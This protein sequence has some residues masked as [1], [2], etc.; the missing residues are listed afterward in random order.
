MALTACLW[1]ISCTSPATPTAEPLTGPTTQWPTATPSVV[2]ATRTPSDVTAPEVQLATVSSVVQP[3]DGLKVVASASDEGTVARMALEVDGRVV[4]EANEG[5][6][7][8]NVDTRALAAGEHVLVVQAW[9][10]AGNVGRAEAVFALVVPTI[11]VQP[12]TTATLQPEP[13]LAL[14]AT[15]TPR[16]T[17]EP[18]VAASV[19][20]P[21]EVYWDE[22]SI[23]TYGYQQALYTDSS[24]GH[25]YP[26]LHWDQVTGAT[27]QTYRTLVLRNAYVQLTL[28][29]DLG[30]R[31]YQCRFLPTGQDLLYNN[32]VIKPTH[33]GPTDQGWWLAVGGIEFCL[34]VDEHGYLT[35]EPWQAEVVR[36]DDGSVTVE[37]SITERSRNL[38]ARVEL[39][40]QP[41][42]A[43]FRLRMVLENP[44]ASAK[45][46]QY[47]VNAMLSPGGHGVQSSLRFYYPTTSVTVHSRGDGALPDAGNAMSWPVADG[48]DLSLYANWRNWLGFFAPDLEAAYT[49]VYD[50]VAS[51]G[52]VRTFASDVAQG[53]K[54]F[55]FGQ[56]FD[57]AVYTDDGTQYVEMWGGLT[58][59][60]WD[61]ATLEANGRVAWDEYWY[62][63]A[64]VDDLSVATAQAALSV[65]R[66]QDALDVTVASPGEHDWTLCVFQGENALECRPCSVQPGV[67]F[68]VRLE[69]VGGNSSQTLVVRITDAAGNE[70]LSY[71]V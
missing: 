67:P 41:Q 16:P 33:W 8:Y 30:G 4:H 9:D 37:L 42:E 31:I 58:P 7:R 1:L 15:P 32:T 35:A 22:V 45:T 18:T 6:L 25:P 23:A 39:T 54:L 71:P 36:Q 59:T 56:G 53:N 5:S 57:P 14:S 49:A 64:G 34:P 26:L 51:V 46:F 27:P 20:A 62:V 55:G 68:H 2:A 28:L 50:P 19:P 61:Y 3:T 24:T 65:T 63:L 52:M 44:E 48:R 29:P 12:V 69:N 13:S 11:T 21:V 47:W 60:F 10:Q 70:V 43:G 38:N 66:D 40:L 17:A